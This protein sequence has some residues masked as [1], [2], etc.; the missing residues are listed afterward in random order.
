M[1]TPSKYSLNRVGIRNST[2]YSPFGVELDGRTV[3]LDGY[4]F[5]YN[6]QEN[7]DEIAG[8]GNHTTALYWEYDSRLG[9]RWNLDPIIFSWQSPYSVNFNNAIVFTDPFGLFGSRGEAREYK[10]NHGLRGRVRKQD[11]GTFA[12]NNKKDGTSYYRD[13]STVG[14]T[15]YGQQDEGVIKGVL[16]KQ[17]A[18]SRKIINTDAWGHVLNAFDFANGAKIELIDYAVKSSS[19]QAGNKAQSQALGKVGTSYLKVAN[20]LSKVSGVIGVFIVG[21]DA[22]QNEKW[23]NHHTADVVIGLGSTFMLSGPWGWTAAGMYF[24]IDTGVQSYTGR[25]ITQN[26]FD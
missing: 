21:A 7:T 9:R 22:Y 17:K 16:A 13:Y 4:R 3:S 26:L 18:N 20:R 23:Q 2:D 24:L 8:K 5:G 12:I 19:H 10:E 6:T 25:S 11:D 15:Y 1:P 14:I